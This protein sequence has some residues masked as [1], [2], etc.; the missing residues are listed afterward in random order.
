MFLR[1]RPDLPKLSLPTILCEIYYI[2]VMIVGLSFAGFVDGDYLPYNLAF[3]RALYLM[4]SSLRCIWLI[5]MRSKSARPFAIATTLV[6][7]ALT[8]VDLICFGEVDPIYLRLGIYGTAALFSVHFVGA[9]AAVC[10]LGFS[11][12]ARAE[13][14]VELDKRPTAAEGQSWDLPFKQR[15]RTWAFWRDTIIYFIVFS[16]L[17]HW[18]EILFCNLILAGVFMGGYDPTNAMLWDQWLFPFSAEG[19]A[20]VM[21]VLVLHPLKE[22]LLE[23]FGGRTVPALAASFAINAAVCTSIDF[24]TGMAVNQDYSLWDYRALPFNFMGQVCLQNS[25]VYSIAAT[26]IVWLVYPA[27]DRLLSRM[28]KRIA[29]GIFFVHLG[30]YIFLAML[31]F[32]V[33]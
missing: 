19:I 28:P 24:L 22:R 26:I 13:L 9:A 8:A 7:M 16:I 14:S 27:M 15:V 18:A 33:V 29:D 30:M 12:H 31:H 4:I 25:L 5:E 1:H 11:R 6:S 10:Y 32:V 17:G 20:L 21:V 3:F 23:R 2:I